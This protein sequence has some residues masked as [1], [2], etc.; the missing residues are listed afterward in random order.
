MQSGM[1]FISSAQQKNGGFQSLSSPTKTPFKPVITYQTTFTA[2]LILSAISTINDSL[3]KN[4]RQKLA[5]WLLA[6][7]SPAWSFNY[8]ATSAPERSNLPYPDDLDD[9]FCA[10]I[11][12]RQHDPT[13]ID[14]ACLGSAVKLLIATESQ[15]G[16]P[17]RTW[18]TSKS[19]PKTWQDVDLAV[20]SNIA[21]FLNMVAEPLP[22][23]TSLIEKSIAS[24]KFVSPYYPSAY[25]LIYYIAR[26]Y[27]GTLATELAKYL[28][29]R[30]RDDW[31]GSP[32]HTALAIS[33]LTR[34]GQTQGYEKAIQHLLDAQQPDGSWQAEAFCL[35]P[36][37][38]GKKYYS[39]SP[40]LTTALALE[41]LALC[42]Q[43]TITPAKKPPT[44]NGDSASRKL[45]SQITAAALE[46][47]NRLGPS[48]RREALDVL[49]HMKQRDK[50]REIA[51]LPHFF[52]NSLANPV[53]ITPAD[54]FIHLGLA[55]L[56]G[57]TAYTIYDDFLDDEG[58]TKLLSVANMALR[59]SVKHFGLAV[60]DPAFQK[61]VERTFDDIDGANAWETSHCRAKITAKTITLG[62]LPKYSKTLSLADRSLGHTL[63]PLGILV[64]AGVKPNDPRAIAV[65]RAL[66]HYIVARQLSDDLHDW[67]QDVRAGRIT[68]VVG[69]ILNELSASPGKY[70][71]ARLLPKMQRQFWH[72]TLANVCDTVTY[73]T[74]LA[75]QAAKSS[76]LLIQPSIIADLVDKIDEVVKRTL[77]EQVKA[78]KFLASYIDNHSNN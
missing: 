14:E 33:A 28:I 55:N 50:D 22:N 43:S 8:W 71:F 31:W 17:Y 52:N 51:L 25:P 44:A 24:R 66:R 62:Q 26:A 78:E 6:Q 76:R 59:Y 7:R 15:V 72:N 37:I 68:Y 42:R 73:H 65:R 27:S 61:L 32:L 41:S 36:A 54:P 3:A 11:A 53:H 10:L 13:L 35:D 19:A 63:T 70:T 48:L 69:K 38:Q 21:C 74:A 4:V 45:H 2:A 18:L 9:T 75:R 29:K 5:E 57:W 77:N 1:A 58:K 49:D 16:G 40:A 20:N 30:R 12:L 46:E 23:L 47:I 60:P 56:Y 64:V 67:E 39:G 34:L